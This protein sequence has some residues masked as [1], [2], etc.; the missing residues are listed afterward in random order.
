LLAL[1]TCDHQLSN[2]SAT[3]YVAPPIHTPSRPEPFHESTVGQGTFRSPRSQITSK[4][5]SGKPNASNDSISESA[6]GVTHQSPPQYLTSYVKSQTQRPHRARKRSL[7]RLRPRGT[8]RF[9]PTARCAPPAH[10]QRPSVP[11]PHPPLDRSGANASSALLPICGR[12][13]RGHRHRGSFELAAEALQRR[14]A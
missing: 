2:G 6:Y 8:E 3:S 11:G 1:V 14:T 13:L 12:R 4:C 9:P 7:P 5:L 10:H